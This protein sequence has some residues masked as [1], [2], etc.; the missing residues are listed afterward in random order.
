MSVNDVKVKF[1]S[2]L[3]SQL[4]ENSYLFNHITTVKV[5]NIKNLNTP[6]NFT[7]PRQFLHPGQLTFLVYPNVE[8]GRVLNKLLNLAQSLKECS[9]TT[10]DVD[11][12]AF[13]I[14]SNSFSKAEDYR[15]ELVLCASFRGSLGT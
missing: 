2:Q 8:P 5:I 9:L 12:D 15:C 1:H 3:G 4:P 7:L 11:N 10:P 14:F 13:R 6:V